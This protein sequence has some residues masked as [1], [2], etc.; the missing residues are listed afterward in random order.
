M[1]RTSLRQRLPTISDVTKGALYMTLAAFLFSLMNMLVQV[2]SADLPPLEVA[3]S[4]RNLH[5]DGPEASH[6][7]KIKS[8]HLLGALQDTGH[9]RILQ[10]PESDWHRWFLWIRPQKVILREP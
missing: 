6:A 4:T 3:T 7:L 2:A 1:L 10:L 8:D 5:P 9:S